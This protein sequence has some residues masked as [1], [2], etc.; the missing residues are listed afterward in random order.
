MAFIANYGKRKHMVTILNNSVE[1]DYQRKVKVYKSAGSDSGEDV[2]LGVGIPQDDF[3]DVRFTKGD[4]TT[5]LDTWKD[6]GTLASGTSVEY[7]VEMHKAGS[8]LLTGDSG[9]D[10]V[11]DVSDGTVFAAS[12]WVIVLD[13]NSSNGEI[14][15]IDSISTNEITLKTALS[16]S[17]TTAQNAKC[18]HVGFLYYNY[19]S[20][21]DPSNGVNTFIE[22]DDFERGNDQDAVGGDWTVNSGTVEISTEQAFGGTRCAKFVGNAGGNSVVQQAET[23]SESILL[24]FRFYKEDAA[25]LVVTHGD[26]AGGVHARAYSDEIISYYD[27][28]S[29]NSTGDSI[30]AD[31]WQLLEFYDFDYTADTYD[32]ALEGSNIQDAAGMNPIGNNWQDIWRFTHSDLGAG[33]DAYLDDYFVRKW[34]ST[35]PTWGTWGSEEVAG[36]SAGNF[37]GVANAAIGKING[38]AIADIG[39]VNGVA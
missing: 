36:W 5:L 33:V 35:E 17:Y 38:V 6:V 32:I 8:S 39:K 11:F 4:E 15:Q 22:F 37:I 18:C 2:Y 16:E 23:A 19:A 31:T 30:T 13:D 26:A 9:A 25:R 20:A 21:T 1:T 34:A 3:D 27:G 7:W 28:G 29:W 24:R 12:D 14:H 10:A